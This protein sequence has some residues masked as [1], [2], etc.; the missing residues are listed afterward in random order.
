VAHVTAFTGGLW[1]AALRTSAYPPG[2]CWPRPALL[3]TVKVSGAQVHRPPC[4]SGLAHVNTRGVGRRLGLESALIYECKSGT[5]D[6]LNGRPPGSCTFERARIR[7]G[8]NS[9][10]RAA[11]TPFRARGAHVHRSTSS[12]GS[13]PVNPRSGR[14]RLRF[15][16]ALDSE[17]KS[18]TSNGLHGRPLGDCPQYHRATRGTAG[19][20]PRRSIPV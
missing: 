6:D 16:S 10:P 3:A 18:G 5:C 19:L 2:D 15:E 13:A 11:P 4:P 12:T 8:L 9:S 17:C 20:V 1:E 7:R 14:R